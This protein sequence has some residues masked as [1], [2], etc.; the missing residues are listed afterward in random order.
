MNT[1]IK[2]VYNDDNEIDGILIE[3]DKL[4]C[5]LGLCRF[6]LKKINKLL[7]G[8]VGFHPSLHCGEWSLH[9]DGSIITIIFS[10]GG[11]DLSG[12]MEY[13]LNKEE[14]NNLIKLL[15]KLKGQI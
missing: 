3:N 8:K 4:K 5:T 7:D 11:K 14:S 10:L 9:Y 1:I 2:A 15:K 12:E 13:K 6:V